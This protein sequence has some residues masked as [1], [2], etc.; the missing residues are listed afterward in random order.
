MN[1]QITRL[2]HDSVLGGGASFVMGSILNPSPTELQTIYIPLITGLLAP[3][4]K[5]AIL[6]LRA[7]RNR[8]PKDDCSNKK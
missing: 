3:L 5:E 4:I 7:Y 8:K 2:A 1:D 6:A